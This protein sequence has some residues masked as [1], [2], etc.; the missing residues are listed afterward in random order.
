MTIVSD[1]L[2]SDGSAV[3]EGQS[4]LRPQ[5]LHVATRYLR[6]G[7]ER[8]IRDIARSFPEADHHLLLGREADADLARRDV[9]PASITIMPT[10]VR[11]PAPLRDL[12]TLGRLLRL[13]RVNRYDLVVTHQSKAG[14][15]ARAAARLRGV[16]AIHSLSMAN[17][18]PGYPGWQTRIFRFIETRLAGTTAAYVVA[19]ADLSRTYA[20]IGVPPEHLH[21]VRS[22]VPLPGADRPGAVK[23]RVCKRFGLPQDRPLLLYLGSLEQRKNVLDLPRLLT[24]LSAPTPSSRPFLVV[25]GE[26]PLSDRLARALTEAGLDDDAKLL[27]YVD[28][29]RPLVSA[30]DVVIL[31]SSAEGV[32]QVLVQ[33]A[34]AGTPFV[35]YAVDGVREL[36]EL[37]AEGVGVPLGDLTAAASTLMDVLGREQPSNPARIDLTSWS[38]TAIRSEYRRV[39][40]AVLESGTGITVD[41][42]DRDE[43]SVTAW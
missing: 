18:G 27:G 16:P 39:I 2:R 30:A 34:A 12:L 5:I 10:L 1:G 31:L 42:S 24:Q 19:G 37:G 3:R 15:L 36:I 7:S 43:R 38:P 13:I 23:S 25:A 28:E 33:A 6:G 9:E 26:G 35:A 29:P 8:R 21:V 4:H 17:F 22:G 14:V 32:P 40:G 20:E 11:R 41:R